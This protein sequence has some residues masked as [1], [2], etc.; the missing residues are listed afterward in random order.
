LNTGKI[1]S[2]DTHLGIDFA[3]DKGVNVRA[4]SDG[5]VRYAKY[6]EYVGN[7]IIIEHGLSFYTNYY[8]LNKILVQEGEIVKK[9]SIIGTVGKTGAATGPHLHWETRVYQIPVDPRSF[10]SIEKIF[11]P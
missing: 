7:M 3:R 10:F 5:I 9:G 6:G 1:Y 8:H 4:S 2:T 11:I